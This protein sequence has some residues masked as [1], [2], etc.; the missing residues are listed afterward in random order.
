MYNLQDEMITIGNQTE[1]ILKYEVWWQIPFRGLTE[2]RVVAI[3]EL[4]AMDLD[5]NQCLVP[6]PVAISESLYEIILR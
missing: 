3:K 6:V 2:D 5:P 4:E 1:P